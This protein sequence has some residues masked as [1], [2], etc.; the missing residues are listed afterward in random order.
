MSKVCVGLIAQLWDKLLDL[1]NKVV[2]IT[3]YPNNSILAY[4]NRHTYGLFYT[5]YI[6]IY[7]HPIYKV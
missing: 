1:K 4:S 2:G 3:F 7:T 6:G 5:T